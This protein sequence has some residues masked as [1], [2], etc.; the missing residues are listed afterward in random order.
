GDALPGR[1]HR[2][3]RPTTAT[4]PSMTGTAR[5]QTIRITIDRLLMTRL[6]GGGAVYQ[7]T[8]RHGH[9][10]MTWWRWWSL[11]ATGKQSWPGIPGPGQLRRHKRRLEESPTPTVGRGDIAYGLR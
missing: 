11:I 4:A 1:I 2:T 3:A 7:C 5:M 9:E 8:A 10:S 6:P